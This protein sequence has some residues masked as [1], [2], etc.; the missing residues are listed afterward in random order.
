MLSQAAF[1]GHFF[2]SFWGAVSSWI[3]CSPGQNPSSHHAAHLVH[4]GQD[5]ARSGEVPGRAE[6]AAEAE[7]GGGQQ[8]ER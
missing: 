2:F 7:A 1:G 6:A 5:P 4:G 3:S 8:L